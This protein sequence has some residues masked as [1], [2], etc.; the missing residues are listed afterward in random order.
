MTQI[1]LLTEQ[2]DLGH[3]VCI[4]GYKNTQYMRKQTTEF[5]NTCIYIFQFQLIFSIIGY[6]THSFSISLGIANFNLVFN[7]FLRVDLFFSIC[8]FCKCLMSS[9]N[10][11]FLDN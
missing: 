9:L 4:L 8:Y 1:R 7:F 6:V 10:L 3:T 2:S 11:C 5:V